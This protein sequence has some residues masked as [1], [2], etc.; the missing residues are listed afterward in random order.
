MVLTT[1]SHRK[2]KNLSALF[3]KNLHDILCALETLFS[4]LEASHCENY[5]KTLTHIPL[6]KVL[7]VCRLIGIAFVSQ[8]VVMC[9]LVEK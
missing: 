5:K 4:L 2:K 9:D 8:E 7:L 3:S 1:N 6:L